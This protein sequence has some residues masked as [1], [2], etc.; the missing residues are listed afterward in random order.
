KLATL[1]SALAVEDER[2]LPV[3]ASLREPL[4]IQWYP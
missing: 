3:P 2:R 1:N 4:T